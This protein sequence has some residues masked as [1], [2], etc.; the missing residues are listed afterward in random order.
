[1]ML[2]CAITGHAQVSLQTG[3]AVFSIP[4]FD[5]KDKKSRLSSAVALNYNSGNGLKV[6][7][8]A[9][10]VGQ[11]WNL[12]IGGVI[13]RMQVGEPDDQKKNDNSN[14]L[15]ISRYPA[16]YMYASVP[17]TN[18]CPTALAR[19]PIFRGRNQL[20]TQNPVM[21][22]DKQLDYFSFQFNGKSGMFVLDVVNGIGVSLGKNKM[23]ITFQKDEGMISQGIRTTI[24]S[25]T[26]QDVDG[27]IY[28][29]TVHG[30]TKVLHAE[31]CDAAS[32]LPMAQPTFKGQHAYHQ[33]AFEKSEITNPYIINTWY[34]SEINDP[35]TNRKITFNYP[36]TRNI[37]SAAGLDLSCNTNEDYV[38]ISHKKSIGVVPALGSIVFPDGHTVTLNYGADRIDFNGDKVLSSVDITYQG[39][40]VSEYQLKTSYMVRNRYGMPVYLQQ[41]VMARLCLL[42][43]TKLGPDLKEDSPPY[44]FDYYL[45]TNATEDFVPPPFFYAKD[46]WGYYNGNNTTS[47][48]NSVGIPMSDILPPDLWLNIMNYQQLKGLCLINQTV[49]GQ[50]YL[51]PKDGFAKNGLLRQ[52]IY[53]TGGTLTYEYE[54]N[55]GKLT[56]GGAERTVG[57]VHVKSTKLT[58]GGRS[59]G[60]SNPLVTNY[61]YTVSGPGS[62]SSM[63]GLEMPVNQMTSSSHYNSEEKK[64]HYKFPFGECYW[65]YAYPG[66]LSVMEAVDLSGIAKFMEAVGPVLD[67][68]TIVTDVVDVLNLVF[69]S[70]GV[71]AW[72]AVI[73]DIIGGLLA[74]GLTCFSGD[75]SKDNTSTVFYNSDLNGAS[76]LPVQF[77]RVETTESSGTAGKTVSEFTSEDDYGIWVPAGGNPH[78]SAGQRFAP[79]AYGLPKKT[80]VWDAGGILVKQVVNTYSFADSSCDSPPDSSGVTPPSSGCPLKVQMPLNLKSTKCTIRK[81]TSQRNTDW[82][83]NSGNTYITSYNND[84]WVDTY[85]LYTGRVELKSTTER[86]YKQND[87]TQLKFAEET[88]Y[89]SYN[90]YYNYEIREMKIQQSN[91]DLVHKYTTYSSDYPNT[92]N[93]AIKKMVQNNIVTVPISLLTTVTKAGASS[94]AAL[95]EKVTEYTQLIGGDV[96]PSKTMEQR[97]SQPVTGASRYSPDNVNNPSIY[98]VTGQSSYDANGNLAGLSDEGGRSMTNIYDYDDRYVTAV[99]VNANYVLD[100]P[101]YTSFETSS[102]GGWYLNGSGAASVNANAIT[103][104]RTFTLSGGTLSAH[105]NNA[106][107]YT[108]S[109][110]A[111]PGLSVTGGGVVKT[112]PTINGL[113]YNEYNIS[114]GTVVVTLSGSAT[115]DELRLYPQMARMRTTA[116]DPIIGQIAECD[117]NNRLQYYEYDNL[118][119][120]KFIKDDYHNTLKMYEYNNISGI[121][122]NG[123]PGTYY[124]S[125]LTE[126]FTRSNCPSGYQ[127]GDAPFT[128]PANKYSSTVSQAAADA[129]AENDLLIHGPGNANTS[130]SCSLIYYNTAISQTYASESCSPGYKGGNVTYTVPA[131]TYSSIIS[132]ADADQ[133]AQDDMD[134]NGWAYANS[135]AHQSCLVDTDPDWQWVDGDPVYCLSINGALPPHQF[136]SATDQN[137]NSPTFHQHQWFDA[138]PQDA[139]PAGNYY[140]A[141]QSRVFTRSCAVGYTGSQ[142]TYTVPPGKYSS[143]TSQAAADQLATDDINAN[144]QNYANDPANGGTC[145]SNACNASNCVGEGKKCINNA[146]VLG[147]RIYTASSGDNTHGYNCIYHYEWPDGTSS[148]NYSY[149]S[150]CPCPL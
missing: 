63:W 105:L 64:W 56:S 12:A 128:V 69:I 58:D 149:H 137:P 106:K 89:F 92:Q 44:K 138:G 104:K 45:G 81:A 47:Y 34:L 100:K 54:Q 29:F 111:T 87:A 132:Q 79:W 50:L 117:E 19:Y 16:G 112:G 30:L 101:L 127:G 33:R 99:V 107:A 48:N 133:Q 18:G 10:N 113:T 20:Y 82:Q 95:S 93:A 11:G 80:T 43:V 83:N 116:Y 46:V 36:Y 134:A 55:K 32:G 60:C 24:T 40:Y 98:K 109:C 1:M 28:K 118:G 145:T 31:F 25:F 108:L 38:I 126:Y 70:S 67:V 125:E 142:V 49:P 88:T 21:Q 23:K 39:R 6:S 4:M 74:V 65:N 9:S 96:V 76:P 66:I 13:A 37:N 131:A 122:L 147:T 26:I 129:L 143:T 7:D 77:K 35:L 17:A 62:A 15:D 41:K 84:M 114:Q 140:N 85:D 59:N 71:M 42:S 51:N 61:S 130:G 146:C 90:S 136:R 139:C 150:C 91:G 5:W 120:L 135:P 14:V 119:R 53:P 94:E 102:L 75:N 52:I 57:G 22:E 148:G 68:I 86:N 2:H 103:G 78:F 110:W 3:T 141:A 73:V 115:I 144:G 121:K 97:F 72:A 124:N 123:C 27:L 8:I